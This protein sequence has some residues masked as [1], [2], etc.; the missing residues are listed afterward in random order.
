LAVIIGAAEQAGRSFP[1]CLVLLCAVR[2]RE[3]GRKG[4]KQKR[5]E[6]EVWSNLFAS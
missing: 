2:A 5:N 3:K 4:K 1:Y 6:E